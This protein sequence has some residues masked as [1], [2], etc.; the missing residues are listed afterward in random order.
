MV[1]VFLEI[2]IVGWL[3]FPSMDPLHNI[4]MLFFLFF[5]SLFQ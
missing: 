5:F 1:I 4:Q 2:K 3:H